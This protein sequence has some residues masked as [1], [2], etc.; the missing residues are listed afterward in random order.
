MVET[1][2]VARGLEVSWKI[3]IVSYSKMKGGMVGIEKGGGQ[4]LPEE[5]RAVWW[6][7]RPENFFPG[8]LNSGTT[9]L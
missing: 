8:N 3:E 4:R 7:E 9:R 5:R 6:I 1:S 2:C